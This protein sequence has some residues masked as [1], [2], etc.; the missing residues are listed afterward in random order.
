M[1]AQP[2]TLT[3]ARAEAAAGDPGPGAGQGHGV[4]RHSGPAGGP[5]GESSQSAGPSFPALPPCPCHHCSPSPTSLLP[6]APHSG[7]RAAGRHLPLLPGAHPG[8]VGPQETPSG[9]PA[10][11]HPGPGETG[12]SRAPALVPL[13]REL[14]LAPR[15]PPLAP[16][17]AAADGSLHQGCGGAPAAAAPAGVCQKAAGEGMGGGAHSVPT[18]GSQPR[19]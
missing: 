12:P 8:R 6:F 18:Q 7:L 14:T 19:G 15:T 9:S 4:P 13:R 10:G 5:P 2:L 17:G 11:E 3:C 1:S 16:P